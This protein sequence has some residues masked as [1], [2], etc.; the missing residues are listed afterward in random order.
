MDEGKQYETRLTVKKIGSSDNEDR[1]F[2]IHLNL[3]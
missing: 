3:C 2:Y 1:L